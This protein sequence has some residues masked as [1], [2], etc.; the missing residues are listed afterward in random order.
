MSPKIAV[1]A[2]ALNEAQFVE[3]FVESAAPADWIIIGDTGSTDGT[4]DEITRLKRPN[5]GIFRMT[6]KPWRFD[7]ARDTVLSLLPADVDVCVS[8]DLDEVLQPGWREEI[9]RVWELGKTTR[10]KYLFNWGGP[11]EFYYEKI[12]A[13]FGYRWHNPCH[14]YPVPYG[15]EEVYAFTDFLMVVHK[16][17]PTKSRH[18][19]LKMLKMSVEEDPHDPR[20]AF[21]YAREHSFGYEGCDP[22]EAIK[23]A[24]RYLGL[25]RANWPNERSYAHRVKA[26]CWEKLGNMAEAEKAALMAVQEA[27]D[28]RE[29]W[30]ALAHVMYKTNRWPECY[31]FAVRCLAIQHKEKVYTTDHAMWSGKPEMY[32]CLGAWNI[33][34]KG[35]SLTYA[36][37]AHML[38]PNDELY[39]KN[40]DFLE[41]ESA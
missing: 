1:Y 37:A 23:Q 36:K 19:Y 16:A 21:Y 30:C 24:D 35:I 5:L 22:A 7:M 15:I 26:D 13:R 4:L 32:A 2:I 27:P 11:T 17:D 6:V 29:G 3:R 25:P 40:L 31:A 10:L 33:G 9:E 41:K 14:E 20:N 34:L 18:Q 28:T 12:H 8:L 39:K 38:D